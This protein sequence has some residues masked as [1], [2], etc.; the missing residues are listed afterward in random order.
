MRRARSERVLV[1]AAVPS[2][3]GARRRQPE[4]VRKRVLACEEPEGDWDLS[5]PGDAKLLS[6]HVAMR[7]CRSWRDAES[8]A[9]FLV[10][11]PSGDQFDHLPL[12]RR[13]AC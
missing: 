10:G 5:T 12:S 9:D 11:T 4:A 1:A 13:N 7:L 3:H 6:K 2:V 8:L